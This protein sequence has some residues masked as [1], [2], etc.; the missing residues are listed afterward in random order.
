MDNY[1]FVRRDDSQQPPSQSQ[2]DLS[3]LN[4]SVMV[5]GAIPAPLHRVQSVEHYRTQRSIPQPNQREI[6]V[7][8]SSP[9]RTIQ[10][11]NIPRQ[12]MNRNITGLM[13]PNTY[14]I[15]FLP[16]ENNDIS[17]GGVAK[18]NDGRGGI[19]GQILSL[20]RSGNKVEEEEEGY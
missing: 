17:G 10:N 18:N 9:K 11:E 2:Q 7:D 15:S 14:S 19:S 8:E 5:G 1:T 3:S 13:S 4:Q 12:S 16:R 6:S 20:D